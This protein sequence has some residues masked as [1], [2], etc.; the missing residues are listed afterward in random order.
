MDKTENFQ[1]DWKKKIRLGQPLSFLFLSATFCKIRTR[2]FLHLVAKCVRHFHLNLFQCFLKFHIVLFHLLYFHII[3]PRIVGD[4]KDKQWQ[5]LHV[6]VKYQVL[7][8][9]RNKLLTFSF[10]NCD[11]V[12][13][14]CMV[15][16]WQNLKGIQ[17]KS[18]KKTG[19]E[20]TVVLFHVMLHGVVLTFEFVDENLKCI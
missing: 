17:H 10:S 16:K 2:W 3:H 12:F 18:Q 9:K 1:A 11:P 20:N 7:K 8:L 19:P 5:L 14:F 4:L 6:G 13:A 15:C